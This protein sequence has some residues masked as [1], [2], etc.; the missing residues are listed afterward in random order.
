[1]EANRD[2]DKLDSFSRSRAMALANAVSALEFLGEHKLLERLRFIG[3]IGNHQTNRDERHHLLFEIGFW[4]IRPVKALNEGIVADL[5]VSCE[6]KTHSLRSEES[7]LRHPWDGDHQVTVTLYSA[8][9]EGRENSV[10]LTCAGRGEDHSH[11]WIQNGDYV[12][13]L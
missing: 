11:N 2:L 7:E 12:R 10:V 1:M 3:S 4:P 6:D 9:N 8:R 5:V 13:Y